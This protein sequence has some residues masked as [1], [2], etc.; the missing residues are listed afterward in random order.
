[1]WRVG[2]STVRAGELNIARTGELNK[3]TEEDTKFELP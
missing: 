1:M 2:V 3:S